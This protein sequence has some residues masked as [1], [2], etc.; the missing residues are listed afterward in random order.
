[1]YKVTYFIGKINRYMALKFSI[2]LRNSKGVDSVK[3]EYFNGNQYL[4]IR[5]LYPTLTIELTDDVKDIGTHTWSTGRLVSFNKFQSIAFIESSKVLLKKF[6]DLKDL[7]GYVDGKLVVNKDL[8]WQNK[9]IFQTEY[10]K[11]VMVMPA[12]VNETVDSNVQYEGV[13]FMI[14]ELSNYV[15]LTY[16][17][18]KAL[19]SYIEKLDFDSLGMQLLNSA[20]LMRN[21]KNNPQAYVIANSSN[22]DEELNTEVTDEEKESKPP[23]ENIQWRN[24]QKPPLIPEI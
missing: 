14:N 2:T 5:G 11:A 16:D 24:I 15:M 7:F 4:F 20:L 17:E 23:D 18:F 21:N 6:Y 19:I 9:S 10:G 8:A 13:S 1:M 3:K 12:V 22:K